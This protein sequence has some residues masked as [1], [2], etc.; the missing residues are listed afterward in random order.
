MDGQTLSSSSR[1][2][3]QWASRRIAR[4]SLTFSPAGGQGT[5]LISFNQ[6]PRWSR[7]ERWSYIKH[8]CLYLSYFQLDIKLNL[9][10]ITLCSHLPPAIKPQPPSQINRQLDLRLYIIF[11]ST[12]RYL[13]CAIGVGQKICIFRRL[14]TWSAFWI[15]CVGLFVVELPSERCNKEGMCFDL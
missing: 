1:Q 7:S 4:S 12:A 8:K 14:A 9:I 3:S 13:S 10:M 5:N 2:S 15:H 11:H 6:I